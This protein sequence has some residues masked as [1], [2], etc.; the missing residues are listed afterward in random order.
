MY[1]TYLTITSA[2]HPPKGCIVHGRIEKGTYPAKTLVWGHIGLG[3]IDN[4]PVLS[5][6]II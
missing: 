4:A 6:N 1:I 2:P 5:T 3:Q